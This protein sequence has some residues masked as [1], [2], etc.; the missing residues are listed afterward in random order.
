MSG[1]YLPF[2]AGVWATLQ[3]SSEIL[4]RNV[5][6]RLNVASG[7]RIIERWTDRI[8]R[9]GDTTIEVVGREHIDHAPPC[10]LMSNHRSHVDIPALLQAAQRSMR[11]VGK[12]ELSRV[13][14]WGP[15]MK[16]LGMIFVSRGD[17]TKAIGELQ[18]AKERFAEGVSIWI[19]P[20]GTRSRDGQLGPFKKGGFHLALDLAAP[21]VPVFITGTDEVMRPESFKIHKHKTVRVA[22]G[23]PIAASGSVDDLSAQVRAAMIVLA[24]R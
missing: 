22:F 7:D 3:A 1:S 4:V 11:L 24:A 5:C 17:K 20:E 19:A 13:P 15:A 23:P 8:I 18:L 10:I 21:I 12:R 2:L 16:Q 6:G 9:A 14:I